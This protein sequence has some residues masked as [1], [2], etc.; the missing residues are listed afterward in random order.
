MGFRDLQAF[1]LAMLAKQ[2]WRIISNPDSLLSRVLRAR[3][4]PHGQVLEASVRNPSFTCQQ[5]LHLNMC[6]M[7]W[8]HALI[9]S[10]FWPEEADLIIKIPLSLLNG[11]DFFCWH[12]MANAKFSV[13]SAY[14]VARDL[15]DQTQ[16]CTSSASS[17]VWK[18][19]WNAKVPKKVQVFGWRLAQNVLPTGVNLNHRMQED[20]FACPLCH[21]E[22]DET[23][24]AF[25]RCPYARQVWSLSQL[26]WA[27]VSDSSTDSCAW[28]ERLAKGIGYEEF[29]F[30]LIICWAIWWNCN[31]TLMEHI[32]LMPDELIKFA[33]HYL[34]TYCQVHAS[35]ENITFASA[36]ARWSPPD[37]N[38]V[39]I[40]FDGAIF[41][42][43]MEL[44]IGVVARDALGNCVGWISARQKR[45]A[46]PELAE[47]F[48]AREAISF[49][50]SFHWQK[51]IL[52]GTVLT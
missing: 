42:S 34:Q 35:P 8:N 44:G 21:A 11:D 18:S 15:V 32:T 5:A 31:R 36:P 30:F 40:N 19:I 50:H 13:C 9:R 48:A 45:L 17:P 28:M 3:Y 33:L 29:D 26:R 24:H 47:A 39:K 52:K 27:L 7:D 23:E 16:P 38:W 10:I 37:T 1:N 12:Y 2:L 43:T 25:L 46:E 51:I 14:H 4:F 41:Q 6:I 49:A 20:S 22:K